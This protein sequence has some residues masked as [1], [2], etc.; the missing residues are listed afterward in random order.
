MLKSNNLKFL[1]IIL[2]LIVPTI[3]YGQN[4]S[5]TSSVY[6]RY[7]FGNLYGTSFGKGDAMGGIGIGTR[8]SYQI[9]TANPASYTAI[10]SLTFLMQFGMDAKFTNS[11]TTDTENT[12]NNVNFNHLTFAFPVTH[13][14]AAS[15]GL[16][17]YATKGYEV[18]TSQGTLGLM[19]NSAFS[20]TGS[21]TRVFLGNGFK[22]GK[23]LSLGVNTWFM[24]GKIQDNTYIYF[25]N[26][27]N[28]YDYLKNNSLNSHGFGVTGGFQYH[29]ETKNK[30]KFTIGATFEPRVNINSTYV[31]QEERALYRGS[32][33][34]SEIV[35][36][37]RH[38]ESSNNGLQTPQTFGTGFSFSLKNKITFGADAYYQKWKDV[39]FLG[40]TVDYL[41]NSSRY[42]AGL[43]YVPNLYSIRSYWARAEYRFGGFYEN[44]YL[45]LNGIQLKTYGITFG[46]G[47]PLSRVYRSLL[48][49]SCELGHM[50]T[51]DN[52]LIKETYAKF[53][54]HIM[55]HDRWFYKTK[56]D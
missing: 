19:S 50:G 44:S 15:F 6:S 7:G 8:D 42:S 39:M 43:E 40:Q 27:V 16:L 34:Y 41:T 11:K 52:N 3:M 55:L 12:R 2:V 33:A 38:V 9:N 21:L 45:T 36:T 23:H 46:L 4:S 24:F 54:I 48:N 1:A 28:A 29:L 26:D 30:N 14:W 47:L 22:L 25:P 17:P 31:I 35:D 10:D 51:T 53:T 20:G 32:T 37:V 56:F 49:L 5:S 18:S 13:W